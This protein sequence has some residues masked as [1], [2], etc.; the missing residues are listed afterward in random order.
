MIPGPTHLLRWWGHRSDVFAEQQSSGIYLPVHDALT[1][2]YVAEH[3]AGL[4]SYGVYTTRPSDQTVTFACF[5]LDVHDEDAWE[6][7]SGLVEALVVDAG[8]LDC[9]CL[10]GE[11]SGNKGKH[12]WLFFDRPTSARRVRRWIQRDFLPKWTEVAKENGWPIALEV[13]PKQDEVPEGSFG[14]LVKLPFGVHKVSGKKSQILGCPGWAETVMDICPMEADLIP[15]VS[16]AE[17]GTRTRRPES[18]VEG[19]GPAS[20]FP[21]VDQILYKGVGKGLRDNAMFHLA[22]YLYGH[23]VPED[24]AEDICFRANEHFDPPLKESEV[25]SKVK[26]AYG[27]R[28][29]SARCGTDWLAGICPGPCRAGWHTTGQV[30]SNKLKRAEVGSGVEVEIVRRTQ[31]EGVTRLTVSHPDAQNTPSFRVND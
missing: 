5:D 20:P 11:Y 13:F 14:N 30:E 2:D 25:R 10:L 27:G 21:C 9:T 3:L 4:A 8:C 7:L 17:V 31:E 12:A 1:E 24:L 18:R 28:Y 6:A 29:Q 16:D 22:L 19:D 23:A 26:G 15:E